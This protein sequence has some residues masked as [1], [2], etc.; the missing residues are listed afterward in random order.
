MQSAF[1]QRVV[2]AMEKHGVK[3]SI[4]GGFAVSLH[5]AVRGT[6]DVD[7]V[8]NH[9]KDQF[10]RC[11]AALKSIGLQPRLPVAAAEVFEFRSEYIEKRNM[12]AWSFINYNN[13]LEIVDIIITHDLQ[14]MKGVRLKVG[15]KGIEVLSVKDLIRMKGDSGRPQ[16]L[17]DIKSLNEILR[18]TLDES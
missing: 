3:Y 14:K 8:I 9:T 2:A 11:E 18:E 5:G 7:A 17:E 12:I 15:G 1:I 4:V 13:P 16:D 10:E 6:V